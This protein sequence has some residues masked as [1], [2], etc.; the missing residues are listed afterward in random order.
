[1]AFLKLAVE[2]VNFQ[3]VALQ[4][5]RQ[6]MSELVYKEKWIQGREYDL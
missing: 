2:T 6:E 1:M 3:L 4:T 5:E